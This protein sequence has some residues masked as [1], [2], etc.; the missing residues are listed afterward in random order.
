MHSSNHGLLCSVR[1]VLGRLAIGQILRE[2]YRYE[3]HGPFV[4]TAPIPP[5]RGFFRRLAGRFSIWMHGFA[6]WS[7]ARRGATMWLIV[8]LDIL[9]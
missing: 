5:A 4:A 2:D 3:V 9:T 8:M 1:R 6:S 7:H